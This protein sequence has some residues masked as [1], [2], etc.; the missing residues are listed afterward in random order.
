M[1]AI[2][3]VGAQQYNVKKDDVIQ[4]HRM[5]G[6]KGDNISIDKSAIPG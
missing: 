6:V 1:Y 2:I 4:V 3:E 5:D